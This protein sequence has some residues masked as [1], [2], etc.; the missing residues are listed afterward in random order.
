MTNDNKL[1]YKLENNVAVISLNQPEI[2][3]AIS[4]DFARELES[5]IDRASS[6]ARAIVLLGSERAF[7]SGANLKSNRFDDDSAEIDL[8]L[9]L[10]QVYNPFLKKLIELPIPLVVGVRGAAAGIGCSIALMGDIIVAGRSAFSLQAFC[11]VGLVP[12]GG[13]AFLLSKSVGRVKAM[14]LMLLAERYPAEQA[15][16][17]GLISRVV[18]N[19]Q[20]VETAM[21]FAEK[22]ARGPSKTLAMIR[23]SAW[24]ALDSSFDD[25]L[26]LERRLQKVAGASQDCREGVAAFREK[27][28]PNF[29]GN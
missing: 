24:A 10:E 28:K 20:V 12:D 23:K 3:N 27:R 25:Q 22:L 13:A 11:N 17:D 29:T 1:L 9:N 21:A 15:L 7:S 5:A 16:Q 6:E 18:D 19:D 8:G 4:P 14:E 26:Q 2:M